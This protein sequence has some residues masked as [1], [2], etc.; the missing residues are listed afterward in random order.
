MKRVTGNNLTGRNEVRISELGHLE[1]NGG[2]VCSQRWIEVQPGGTLS[3]TGTI[4]AALYSRGTLSV[5]I[6]HDDVPVFDVFGNARLAGTLQVTS[7]SP[8]ASRLGENY[9]VLCTDEIQGTF[10][11]PGNEVVAED[12]TRFAIE[13]TSDSVLLTVKERE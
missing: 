2:T 5:A 8:T 6:G 1:L 7:G 13:H 11:N 9:L 10:G 4:G 12:G 3:G